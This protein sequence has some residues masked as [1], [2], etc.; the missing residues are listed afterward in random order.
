MSLMRKAAIVLFLLIGFLSISIH[1]IGSV[2]AQSGLGLHLSNP[3]LSQFP[4]V[5]LYLDVYDQLG[6]FASD[7][8]LRNVRLMEDGQERIVNET[9]LTQQ[10]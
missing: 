8:T 3:D 2:Q 4:K 6:N 1:P 9:F 7:L 10:P 5:T